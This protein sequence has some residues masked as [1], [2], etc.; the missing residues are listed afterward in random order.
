MPTRIVRRPPQYRFLKALF[1]LED[2]VI[3]VRLVPADGGGKR[4]SCL[5]I[6][7][8]RAVVRRG[9]EAKLNVLVGIA[10]RRKAGP[11]NKGNLNYTA[12]I[13]IDADPEDARARK[14]LRAKLKG[15]EPPPSM[16]VRSGAGYHAYWLLAKPFSLRTVQAIE[17][18]ENVLKGLAADFAADFRTTDASRA[19]RVPGTTNYPGK[20]KQLQGRTPVPCRLLEPDNGLRYAL[21]DF[22]RFERMGRTQRSASSPVTPYPGLEWDGEL[23]DAVKLLLRN[24][25]RLGDLWNGDAR[26]LKDE[27]DSGIDLAIANRLATKLSPVD[28]DRA[29]QM[30]EATLRFR[31][32]EAGA[33]SKHDA[34]YKKTVGKALE[35]HDKP[36]RVIR[37]RRD[38]AA[39]STASGGPSDTRRTDTAIAELFV[40]RFR[41][42]FSWIPEKRSWARYATGRWRP[43]GK[44]WMVRRMT[45]LARQLYREAGAEIDDTRR[46][47]LAEQA[48]HLESAKGIRDA[49]SIAASLLAI[50]IA[51]FDTKPMLLNLPNGTLDLKTFVLRDHDPADRLTKRTRA[52]YHPDARS[53]RWDDFLERVLP[54]VEVRTF[55]QRALGSCL[56]GRQVKNFF[57]VYGPPDSGKTTALEAV[58]YVL[59][60]YAAVTDPRTFL[61]RRETGGNTPE[62]AQLAGIRMVLTSEMPPRAVLDSALI[63]KWTGRDTIQATAKYGHPFTYRPQG[64]LWFVGND[65][66]EIRHHE[67][68]MWQRLRHLE[69]GESIPR[70]ERDERFGE[71]LRQPAH[72]AAILTWLVEGLRDLSRRR[73][74]L[75]AP[76]AVEQAGKDHYDQMDPLRFLTEH[77]IHERGAFEPFGRL[78]SAYEKWAKEEDVKPI[79]KGPF[80]RELTKR[81]FG[82]KRMKLEGRQQR[83]RQGLRL[84]KKRPAVTDDER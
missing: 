3:D 13:F 32:A 1:P 25:E 19:M 58:M 70:D 67:K 50:P 11:G 28:R 22:A 60:D 69:F 45:Q 61:H 78:Y 21:E 10:S 63:K 79:A 27:S 51:R 68:P 14:E 80:G 44:T 40:S 24:D 53:K 66:P 71:R 35:F 6:D 49:G 7:R 33:K 37:S 72:A 82:E 56:A 12:A 31:R 9:V 76:R 81:G 5:G 59:G 43:D 83:V 54:D 34:Y 36:K 73:W 20:A 77:C 62:L 64:T 38:G 15:F 2:P 4:V 26:G 16:L 39:Q 57:Y 55:F 23:P 29:G 30:I 47:N 74:K 17:R 42:E 52:E 48:R 84:R 46:T 41:Y 65:R 18:Y 8:A 75:E